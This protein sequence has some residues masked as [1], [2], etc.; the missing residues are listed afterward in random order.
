MGLAEAVVLGLVQGLTEFLPISSSAHLSVTG[1]LIG[2]GD[3]G[4]A[5]TAISQLGTEAAVIIYFRRDIARIVSRWVGSLA[6]RVPRGDPDA[7][8][9]WLVI[10]GSIPIGV[11]GLLFKDQIE[12][13]LRGYLLTATTLW[14]FALLLGWADRRGAKERELTQLTWK[15][16]ILFGLA[17]SLALIPGVS[18]SGG[19]ITAGL[20]LG[21]TREAAARYSF[22]LAIPAV[23]LS[24]FFQLYEEVRDGASVPWSATIVATAIAFVVGYAVI[25]WLMRYITT[26]SYKPFVVY[27]IVLAAV[28]YALVAAAVLPPFHDLPLG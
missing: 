12:T 6:G 28:V 7:R 25:A 22:L 3:P 15:H 13:V 21:Y 16:G 11:F 23:V 19:T 1:Q 4:A 2:A 5:F 8:M 20:L 18:R 9:G 10:L 26:H 14:V 24:G 27:R 17:Q